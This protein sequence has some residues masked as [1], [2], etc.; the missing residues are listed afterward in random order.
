MSFDDAQSQ[1]MKCCDGALVSNITY[2]SGDARLHLFRGL[3]RERQNQNV[4]CVQLEGA[5]QVGT[6]SSDGQGLS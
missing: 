2:H 4:R 3:T 1:T 5:Y 6:S